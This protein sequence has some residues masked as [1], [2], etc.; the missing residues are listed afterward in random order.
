MEAVQ[1]ITSILKTQV[2][3]QQATLQKGLN[4]QCVITVVI[5]NGY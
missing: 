1:N 4:V 5:R 3:M 2:G